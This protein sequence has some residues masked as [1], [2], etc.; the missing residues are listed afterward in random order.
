[1]STTTDATTTTNAPIE[2]LDSRRY[3]HDVLMSGGF[4]P[5]PRWTIDLTDRVADTSV[6]IDTEL[7]ARVRDLSERFNTSVTAV[8]L[9]AHTHVVAS[10]T[11]E[12]DVVMGLIPDDEVQ[13][14]LPC[15][16][17]IGGDKTFGELVGDAAS[18]AADATRHAG[19]D[20]GA[21]RSDLN[22]ETPL[23][24]T[25]VGSLDNT[26]SLPDA[27][28][29]GVGVYG[30]IAGSHL[31]VRHHTSHFSAEYATRIAGYHVRALRLLCDDPGQ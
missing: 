29:L 3:W 5:L 16:L 10:L 15:H 19:F 30:G 18:V 31:R 25:V 21:L 7:M 20:L 23:F 12:R 9:A 13:V 8:L 24:E 28:W 14:A 2:T 1:M 22:L 4:T 6:G 17:S 26:G 11:G 27:V